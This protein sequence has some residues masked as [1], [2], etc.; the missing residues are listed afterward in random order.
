MRILGKVFL[1]T[2]ILI[3]SSGVGHV[4]AQVPDVGEGVCVNCDSGSSSSYQ[5]TWGW[6]PNSTSSSSSG[7]S[8][9]GS[10]VSWAQQRQWNNEQKGININEEGNT[11]FNNGDYKKAAKYY[12]KA[13]RYN[14][15][16]AVILD[17]YNRARGYVLDEEGDVLK[18]QGN[19]DEAL[20]KY[21]EAAQLHPNSNRIQ[22]NIEYVQDYINSRVEM[23]R[24]T[25]QSSQDAKY[26]GQDIRDF[27]N[28]LE[29][30]KITPFGMRSNGMKL[31]SANADFSK[32]NKG[33]EGEDDRALAQIN[34]AKVHGD[35]ALKSGTS[36]S[37][38]AEAS[39]VFD[40]PGSNQ[41][42][43]E[44]L[45][46]AGIPVTERDPDIPKEYRTA[47]IV[48]LVEERTV[49]RAERQDLMKDL[50]SLNASDQKDVMKIA[51]VK[52]KITD[53]EHKEHFINFSIK[54]K[55]KDGPQEIEVNQ[56]KKEA[57]AVPTQT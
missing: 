33:T 43:I 17:N 10:G 56:E 24:M 6:D 47:E 3:F 34:S 9:G 45:Q 27:A 48:K 39:R 19:Y 13:I 28:N 36:E 18:K 40:S 29:P 14:P 22:R 32:A 20:V 23:D 42:A 26:L 16:D 5:S 57:L 30:T 51:E 37:M 4:S 1:V 35:N 8:S 46:L 7:S 25:K 53:I 31:M 44:S 54:K 11:Y 12:E 55:M 2:S 15:N 21:K 50:E 52:Q 49:M 38:H 41:H